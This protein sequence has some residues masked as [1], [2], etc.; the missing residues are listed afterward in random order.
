MSEPQIVKY[1]VDGTIYFIPRNKIP[2]DSYLD[3]VTTTGVGGG[4]TV[5]PLPV[6]QEE[7]EPVYQW[8]VN[9]SIP[10]KTN[11]E[12]FSETLNGLLINPFETYDT[13][14]IV[15]EDMR[16]H[17]YQPG[18]EDHPMNTDPHYGLIDVVP[19]LWEQVEV[20]Q[21]ENPN[22]LFNQTRIKPQPWAQIYDSLTELN[23][24][25]DVP[26]VFIAGGRVFSAL[27]EGGGTATKW[28]NRE[29]I[30]PDYRAHRGY[31]DVDLFLI[32][33]TEAEGSRRIQQLKNVIKNHFTKF[34]ATRPTRHPP[35]E[36]DEYKDFTQKDEDRFEARH[37]EAS[38]LMH[39]EPYPDEVAEDA[40]D[41][42]RKIDSRDRE[43]LNERRM[44][45]PEQREPLLQLLRSF[46]PEI[47]TENKG[48]VGWG[49]DHRSLEEFSLYNLR[50]LVERSYNDIHLKAYERAHKLTYYDHVGAH[51]PSESIR[52]KTADYEG[53]LGEA[54]KESDHFLTDQTYDMIY[55]NSHP[56]PNDRDIRI[57]KIH[58]T[59]TQNALTITVGQLDFQIILRLYKSPSEV[60]HGFDVDCCSLGYD[61]GN[62]WATQ[63]AIFS[64][65]NGYNT[66]N[67]DRLSPSY[68]FRLVKYALRGMMIYAPDFDR[69]R[70][71]EE[72]LNRRFAQYIVDRGLD[73]GYKYIKRMKGLDV[74]IY[75]EYHWTRLDQHPLV[76]KSLA[77][78]VEAKSDYNKNIP[79]TRYFELGDVGQTVY[80]L[81]EYLIKS[82]DLYPEISAQYMP[83]VI[84][85]LEQVLRKRYQ[86]WPLAFQI[87]PVLVMDYTRH[88]KNTV[89]S[90]KINNFFLRGSPVFFITG[91]QIM[92]IM[93][94][95]PHLYAILRIL[96][97]D[98]IEFPQ[99]VRFKIQN[100]GEQ[101]TNTFNRLVLEDNRLWYTGE[102]YEP[103]PVIPAV[104]SEEE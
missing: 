75:A 33:Q 68:P 25:F 31:S 52:S 90:L 46:P 96:T 6:S 61:G 16:A 5:H 64:L 4:H 101:M 18:Y 86:D 67:F 97:H 37:E 38:E 88:L 55:E 21:P 60:L 103:P 80:K 91:D 79:F 92:Q 50:R 70:V 59:R 24:L 39:A 28:A 83:H 51:D 81:L 15:E 53:E 34:L 47:V 20:D 3:V 89:L 98:R 32:A 23:F 69:A 19:D 104:E 57:I 1:S 43:I 73:K 58:E 11:M 100:P 30:G 66:V 36:D 44:G 42:N 48:R 8:L 10:L 78:L 26:G 102:F 77:K 72:A 87:Y 63:R 95:N 84:A 2:K 12:Q 17:M 85:L 54:R 27:F 49:N 41:K 29:S 74:I 65:L 99:Q 45:T 76:S 62:I 9:R 94:V 93:S 56:D 7:F 22:L 14:L 35:R 40:E 13:A 82:A 71:N